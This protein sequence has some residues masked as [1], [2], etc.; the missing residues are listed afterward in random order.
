[1]LL[2]LSKPK[3]TKYVPEVLS[4][5]H[6]ECFPITQIFSTTISITLVVLLLYF[7]FVIKPIAKCRFCVDLRVK[8]AGYNLKHSHRAMFV[9]ADLTMFLR[10]L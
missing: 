6:K 5:T 7:I 3:F 8:S 9:I 4:V 10:N 1:M 2:T